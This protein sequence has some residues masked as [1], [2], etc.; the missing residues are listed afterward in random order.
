MHPNPA[1]ESIRH[2]AYLLWEAD[3][4]PHGRDEHYWHLASTR[5]RHETTPVTSS[6]AASDAP[7][8]KTEKAPRKKAVPREGTSQSAVKAGKKT[9]DGK[10]K[11]SR[12][13]AHSLASRKEGGAK[14]QVQGKKS[15]G[16][17]GSGK[18][19]EA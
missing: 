14:A 15:L 11:N 10:T 4:R 16:G 1:E 12:E 19:R 5:L 13:A 17:A 3:G 8:T 6:V 7:P 18:Q 9:S 2:L